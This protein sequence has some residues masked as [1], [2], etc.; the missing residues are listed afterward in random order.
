MASTSILVS[1]ERLEKVRETAPGP[2]SA[3]I[4]CASW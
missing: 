1:D 3:T 4:F 2:V